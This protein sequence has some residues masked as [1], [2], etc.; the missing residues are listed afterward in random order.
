MANERIR[1][2]APRQSCR[3]VCDVLLPLVCGAGVV[4]RAGRRA[5]AAARKNAA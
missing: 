4:A 3:S 5:G 1:T 2:R